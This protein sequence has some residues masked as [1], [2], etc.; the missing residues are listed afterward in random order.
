[1]GREEQLPSRPGVA[2]LGVL[3]YEAARRL[4][5]GV[6]QR[7]VRPVELETKQ[8]IP[9]NTLHNHRR[10][11]EVLGALVR[12]EMPGPPRFVLYELSTCGLGLRELI[13]SVAGW[14]AENALFTRDPLGKG[15]WLAVAALSE[16]WSA[17]V[18]QALL[19]EPRSSAELERVLDH[20]LTPAQRAGLLGRL[21]ST[22]IME[23]VDGSRAGR[24]G[25]VLTRWGRAGVG[26]L[27]VMAR[28]EQQHL[29]KQS[30]PITAADGAGALC[31]TLP[32][33]ELPAQTS[34]ILEFTV[35]DDAGSSS[36]P[37]RVWANVHGGRV[38]RCRLGRA[39][40][41][42]T[43]RAQG[44][45]DAWLTA[46]LDGRPSKL[47]ASGELHLGARVVSEL[48]ARLFSPA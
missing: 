39:P 1:M 16:G 27:A 7:M 30:T 26:Q 24:G 25:Y 2:V 3:R 42:A 17:A 44:S 29:P 14:L 6:G 43:V 4:L 31:A 41:A 12:H 19:A 38:M 13:L 11:L 8:Q 21:R 20:R 45:I 40:Q 15:A 37:G 22:G 32:L 18:V 23:R 10:K 46:V 28:F 47:A 5:I 35:T 48:H 33:I 34:A 9:R 36:S